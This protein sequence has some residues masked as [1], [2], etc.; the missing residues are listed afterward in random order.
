MAQAECVVDTLS[1]QNRTQ[2]NHLFTVLCAYIKLEMLKVTTQ[3]N[4]FVR[5]YAVEGRQYL[6]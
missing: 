5:T 3:I 6:R 1:D 2:S 4:H